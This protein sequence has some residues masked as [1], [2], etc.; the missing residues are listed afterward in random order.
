MFTS[1]FA[2]AIR[3]WNVLLRRI[4]SPIA[5]SLKRISLR[6]W[7]L[8]VMT[9]LVIVSGTVL[10]GSSIYII[11]FSEDTLPDVRTLRDYRP[12]TVTMVYDRNSEKIAE[13]YRERRIPIQLDDVPD[14]LIYAIL[15][16]ED[17]NFFSHFGIDAAGIIRAF[18]KNIE[19]RIR[20]KKGMQGGS[21][22]TQQLARLVFLNPNDRSLVRKL[23]E[24]WLALTIERLFTKKEILTLYI[25]Q[26][27]LSEGQYGFAAAADYYFNKELKD[28]TVYDAAMLAGIIASPNALSPR[29]HPNEAKVRRDDILRRME[30]NGYIDEKEYEV[31]SNM[32]V[33]TATP[34][35]SA[36]AE[37]ALERI[38]KE[39]AKTLPD[40]SPWKGD[41]VIRTTLDAGLQRSAEK[42]IKEGIAEYESRNPPTVYNPIEACMLVIENGTAQ[43]VA[44]VGGRNFAHS[45]FDHCS[46][47]RRQPGSV[48]KTFVLTA[49]LENTDH[50]PP[51]TL[52]STV[53]DALRCYGTPRQRYCPKNYPSLHPRY[54]GPIPLRKAFADSRNAAFVWLGRSI[55]LDAIIRTA[56]QFGF[57]APSKNMS[58][59]LGSS[60]VTAW[61]L[62]RAFTVFS[63]GGKLVEPYLIEE[64]SGKEDET[65]L[66]THAYESRTA[67]SEQTAQIMREALRHVVLHGTGHAAKDLPIDISGKTG[68]T[69]R[70]NPDTTKRDQTIDAWFCGYSPEYTACVWTGFDRPDN[71]GSFEAGAKTALPI[72]IKF[73]KSAYADDI[74]EIRKTETIITQPE[75]EKS[76]AN[77]SES[78][79]DEKLPIGI[80]DPGE[81]LDMNDAKQ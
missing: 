22:I 71:I 35:S 70:K 63:N 53:Y 52:D 72:F 9:A 36:H 18:V 14:V 78:L 11:F 24:A 13:W 16:A 80:V 29:N 76:P 77:E 49:A 45:K 32:P 7:R 37:H 33:I 27:Y 65:S 69:S 38:K 26:V 23:H 2:A 30:R 10:F 43:V 25:N 48:F 31:F 4:L 51:W 41:L 21:T 64:V 19:S 61:E 42:A 59:I 67:V 6:F 17:K 73:M 57:T 66:M 68:T 39:L 1:L 15:S 5:L 79:T 20:N 56:Q 55:G 40:N 62:T 54:A 75:K 3:I 74:R 47:S 60:E 58:L 34:S 28:L 46:Q 8:I 81:I 12:N 44:Y 50:S